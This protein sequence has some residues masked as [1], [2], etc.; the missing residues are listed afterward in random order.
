MWSPVFEKMF[1]SP[2][3]ERNAKEVPLPGKRK[4]EI[5]VLLRLIYSNGTKEKVNGRLIYPILTIAVI[6]FMITL[7]SNQ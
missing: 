3:A 4:D 6:I 1:N 2:F 5:E 7:I